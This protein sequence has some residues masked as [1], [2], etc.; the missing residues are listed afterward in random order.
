VSTKQW[1]GPLAL[2]AGIVCVLVLTGWTAL[3]PN[4][5]LSFNSDHLLTLGNARSYMD[6]HVFRWNDRLGFPAQRD[7]MYHATFYLPQ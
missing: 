7:Q 5:P 3:R 6:G 4:E 2:A 1:R